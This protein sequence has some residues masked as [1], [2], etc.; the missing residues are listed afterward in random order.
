MQK[1]ESVR[2]NNVNKGANRE[3]QGQL[4]N[5][6]DQRC[7]IWKVCTRRDKKNGG[8][9]RLGELADLAS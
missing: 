3:I 4:V 1:E 7:R 8:G 6:P 9:G 5:G 2:L